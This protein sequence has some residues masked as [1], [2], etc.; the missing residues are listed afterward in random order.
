VLVIGSLRGREWG[1]G[2][3]Y[4]VPPE[5]L[6]LVI[7]HDNPVEPVECADDEDEDVS[8]D[9]EIGAYGHHEEAKEDLFLA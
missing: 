4:P 9:A 2:G 5:H 8:C 3:T 7:G 1:G 6:N